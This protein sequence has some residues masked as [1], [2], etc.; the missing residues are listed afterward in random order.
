M[1]GL[2][3]ADAV[4]GEVGRFLECTF[5]DE[6]AG[7]QVAWPHAF[8]VGRP[9]KAEL[10]GGLR[11]VDLLAQELRRWEREFGAT[12]RYGTREAGGLQRV[13]THVELPSVDAAAAVVGLRERVHEP[14]GRALERTRTR[15]AALKDGFPLLGP[16]A[17]ARVLRAED[18]RDDL[19][20]ELL[21][22]AGAW[23]SC[24]DA[25]GLTPRQVPLPGIDGKWLDAK[26]LRDF[27][28]LLAGREDLGLRGH[29]QRMDFAYLDPGHRARGGRR[30]D[31]W[32]E[33][34]AS[35]PAYVPRVLL[36]V[37]NKAS[38]LDFPEVEGGIC[39]FGS[40]K[41]GMAVTSAM[42]LVRSAGQ[43]VYWGDLDADGFQILDGYRARGVTCASILMDGY[44]LARYGRYGT[45]L[46][47][48]HHSILVRERLELAHLTDAERDA[49]ERIT[50]PDYRG[51]RRI[52][53]EKI[54]LVDALAA[55]QAV[56]ASMSS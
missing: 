22:A 44:A 14:W 48:D 28:C 38:Y 2:K 11:D 34:D 24:H 7:V 50:D 15:I 21:L 56:Q 10:V 46:G 29:P 19:E 30:Y 31:S 12:V 5:I 32:V 6:L 51:Y 8:A 53:Q 20:F 33:G 16:E 1:A 49:Y 39:L 3:S 17:Y 55:L 26:R 41:A 25:A 18:A 37:E 36:I 54:P 43:V 4:R 27:V 42:P 35:V 52:E 47:K 9:S 45:N 13:P 23:F 40:G